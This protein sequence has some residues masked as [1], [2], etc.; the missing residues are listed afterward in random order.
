MLR[1][2]EPALRL[3]YDA[4]HLVRGVGRSVSA[5][6]DSVMRSMTYTV[7]STPRFRHAEHDLHCAEHTL[8]PSCGA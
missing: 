3:V 5:Q 7:R 6:T 2:T 8:I 4:V 1:M